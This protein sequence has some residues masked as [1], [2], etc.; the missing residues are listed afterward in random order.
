M[1][2]DGLRRV[3]RTAAA[4]FDVVTSR[5]Q[6]GMTTA[7]IKEIVRRDTSEPG[8][9]LSQLGCHAFRGAI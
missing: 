1:L 5:P 4:T 8:G 7:D 2:I 3:G 6:P 9:T